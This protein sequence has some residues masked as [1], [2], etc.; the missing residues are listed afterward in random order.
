MDSRTNEPPATGPGDARARASAGARGGLPSAQA[1]ASA[2]A[3]FG[4]VEFRRLWTIGMLTF[5]VRWLEILA[6]GVYGYAQT[7]SAVIVAMLTMLRVL[8]MGLFG[9]LFGTLAARVSRRRGVLTYLWSSWLT[10]SVLLL[11][12]ALGMLEIWHLAVASFVNG[13]AWAADN[14]FRRAMIGDAVGPLN[15]G[16]AM[17]LDVGASN[18]S[19]LAGPALGGLLLAHAGI[20]GIF[21]FGLLAYSLALLAARATARAP[22][23][24]ARA[25]GGLRQAMV[26]GLRAARSNPRLAGALWV[27]IVF[28]LFGWPVTSMVPVIARDQLGLDADGTGLLASMDG[29]GA[30][31]AAVALTRYARP[32]DYGRLYIGGV[33]LYLGMVGLFAL[34]PWTLLAGTA[35][36]G[37]GTGQAAFAVMQATLIYLAA[38]PS[39]RTQAMGLLTM[40]I[41]LGPLGFVSIGALADFLSAPLAAF[42]TALVGVVAMIASWPWWRAVW[43]EPPPDTGC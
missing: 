33:L 19:R 39:T 32:S 20:V 34:A 8:P 29:L 15:M 22:E 17:T 41:G 7:G 23:S 12:A 36:Y 24:D 40:C 18:A 25:A 11:I 6:Y 9:M 10:C 5:I 21:V 16:M 35:L 4:A 42:I 31:I 13:A 30:L 2:R 26:E 28:N 14:P 1:P 27:T 43:R 37:M 3:L 38:T